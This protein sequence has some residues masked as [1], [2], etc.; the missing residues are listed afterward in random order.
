VMSITDEQIAPFF[1]L[2]TDRS[3]DE[4]GVMVDEMAGGMNPMGYKKQ[5]AHEITRLY[6]G[7]AQALLAQEAFEQEIQGGR[8]PKAETIPAIQLSREG[9]WLLADLLSAVG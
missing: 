1:E 7:D 8:A 4:L 5:L 9:Q 3:L 6:H 2:C